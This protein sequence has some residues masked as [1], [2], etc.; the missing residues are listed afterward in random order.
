MQAGMPKPKEIPSSRTMEHT[1][2]KKEVLIAK[3][4]SDEI[5]PNPI[6]TRRKRF[7]FILLENRAPTR[8]ERMIPAKCMLQTKVRS[9]LLRMP[10]DDISARTFCK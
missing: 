9:E 3:M 2:G 4:D 10:D 8:A 5:T 7:D 6:Q 1:I